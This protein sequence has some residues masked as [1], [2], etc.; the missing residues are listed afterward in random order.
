VVQRQQIIFYV[1]LGA[2][3][4]ADVH[5]VSLPH[6]RRQRRRHAGLNHFPQDVPAVQWAVQ[7]DGTGGWTF[8]RTY[9]ALTAQPGSLAHASV[10]MMRC[11][12]GAAC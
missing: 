8:E 4:V 7:Y 5:A 11:M 6:I 12:L 9:V 3:C 1:V 10:G 2:V